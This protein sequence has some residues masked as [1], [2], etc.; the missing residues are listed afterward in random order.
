MAAKCLVCN[1]QHSLK[2]ADALSCGV[3][4]MCGAALTSKRLTVRSAGKVYAVCCTTCKAT[5]QRIHS[6]MKRKLR[7]GEIT[8]KEFQEFDKGVVI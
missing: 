6:L 7:K 8:Q 5:Y 3:C 4:K 1:H 2:K